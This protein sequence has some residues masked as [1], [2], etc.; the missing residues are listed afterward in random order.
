MD[1]IAKICARLISNG[2]VPRHEL[3]ALEHAATRADVE[4]RLRTCGLE[5]A[6]SAYS[7]HFGLRLAVDASDETVLDAASNIGLRADEC[8]LVAVLW[9]RLAL[10]RRTIEDTRTTPD[11][12]QSLLPEEAARDARDF[13]PSIH[14]ETLYREFGAQLGGR[15]RVKQMLAHLRRLGFVHYRTLDAIE[16]GPQLE[17]GIDGERMVSFIRTRVLGNLLA[18]RDHAATEQLVHTKTDADLVID[19]L[20]AT[21]NPL[22]R[23]D[24]RERTA[25]SDGRL[26]RVLEELRAAGRVEMDGLRAS[27]VYRLVRAD[28]DE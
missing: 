4:A 7:D 21:A 9:A 18:A 20:A 22:A 3:R 15:T 14:Q 24:I 5:L 6:T 11:A 1:E 23:A 27:A 10:Q 16:P 28:G 8:A 17:L 13:V 26:R 12:Q 25:L 2:A 19:A